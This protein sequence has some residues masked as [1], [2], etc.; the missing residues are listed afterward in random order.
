MVNDPLG[1]DFYRP[2]FDEGYLRARKF[3]SE[4]RWEVDDRSWM[5]YT[6]GSGSFS[7]TGTDSTVFTSQ[8][9]A[10]HCWFT[11]SWALTSIED[12]NHTRRIKR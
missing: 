9:A 1:S 8:D 5:R 11:T 4:N 6:F 10:G 7:R 12:A 3:E 2:K